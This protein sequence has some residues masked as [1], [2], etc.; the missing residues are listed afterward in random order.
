MSLVLA[1]LLASAA[2]PAPPPPPGLLFNFYRVVASQRYA[3]ALGCGAADLD[4]DCDALRSR[5]FKRRGKMCFWPPKSPAEAEG[6]CQTAM[7]VYRVD[8]ADFR[9]EADA[10]LAAPIPSSAA[11]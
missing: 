2:V 11:E 1:A 5:L 7:S 3:R 10:A 9:A 4:R 6:S 8:R